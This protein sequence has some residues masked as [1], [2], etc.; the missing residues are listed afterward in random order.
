VQMFEADKTRM[1]GLPFGEKKNYNNMLNRFHL[2][3]E[4]H[5]RRT[6]RRTKLLGLYQYRARDK[7]SVHL[8]RTMMLATVTLLTYPVFSVV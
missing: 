7:N 8:S 6:D 2:I 1:I 5:R 4:R 3:P